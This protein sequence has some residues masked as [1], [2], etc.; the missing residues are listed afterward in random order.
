M[1]QRQH[2]GIGQPAAWGARAAAVQQIEA[3][4]R[5]EVTGPERRGSIFHVHG[6]PPERVVFAARAE[7]CD[8][9]AP[10]TRMGRALAGVLD[11]RT[12][13]GVPG[14][15]GNL[16]E[17]GT[18]VRDETAVVAPICVAWLFAGGQSKRVEIGRTEQGWM[19]AREL[20]AGEDGIDLVRLNER[21]FALLS[22]DW[23][24]LR[25]PFERA[26]EYPPGQLVA[27]EQP[28]VPGAIVLDGPTLRRRLFR[29]PGDT[30]PL[31]RNLAEERFFV[32]FPKER[33]KRR[34]CG[35]LVWIHAIDGHEPPLHVIAPVCDDLGLAIVSIADAGN[36][37]EVVDRLQ[38]VLDVVATVSA[39]VPIDEHRIY[40]AGISGGGRCSSIVWGCFPDVFT[41]AV[42]I[43]GLDSYQVTPTGTGR[44]WRQSYDRPSGVLLGMLR[45]HR[46]AGISG[47]NDGNYAEMKARLDL[48]SRDGQDVHLFEQPGM[49]HEMPTAETFAEAMRWVDEVACATATKAAEEGAEV[50]RRARAAE[51]E[52]RERLLT[53][54]IEESPWSDAA[55]EAIDLLRGP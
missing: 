55:W 5:P 4:N 53:K 35:L 14:L 32:R 3:T 52:A 41:G 48:L 21:R 34:P 43:V 22:A 44:A 15:M 10:S 54:V 11:E 16:V 30:A 17:S 13:T 47:A 9:V 25:V 26:A 51:G 8:G 45:K 28:Y 12:G 40:A 29:N 38:L 2:A 50:L 36:A 20:D 39:R 1:P 23:P 33:D 37:R 27:L 19:L 24:A 6:K 42:P 7:S 31:D 49:G 18:R 46:M